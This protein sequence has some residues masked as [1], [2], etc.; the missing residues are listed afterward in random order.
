V[1][2]V[3]D[4]GNEVGVIKITK[5]L[6]T[7]VS[8]EDYPELS[9]I[10][11]HASFGTRTKAYVQNKNCSPKQMHRFVLG[12]SGEHVVDRIN[13]ITLDNRREN[14]RIVTTAENNRNRTTP[15]NNKRKVI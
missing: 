11:W 6:H 15:T 5:G 2:I 12:Y 13:R 10:K 9:K 3:D 8:P 4:F 14:L 1:L 7:L